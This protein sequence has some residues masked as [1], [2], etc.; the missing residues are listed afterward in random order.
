MNGN[1]I[2]RDQWMLKGPL[3]KKGYDWWWHS[4][5]GEKEGTE[6]RKPFYVEFFTCNPAHAEDE[7]VIVWNDK[8]KQEAGILPSYLMVNVGYW[9]EDH[10]QLH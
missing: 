1:D 3:A 6:E 2:S 7:P 8:Q 9:G 5:T 4:F 10:G